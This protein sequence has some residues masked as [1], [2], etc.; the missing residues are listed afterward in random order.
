[1][2]GFLP[3]DSRVKGAFLTVFGGVCWGLSGSMGQ[4]LFTKQGMDSRWLVPIRLGL[5]GIIMF[6]YCLIRYRK[7]TFK[8]ISNKVEFRSWTIR[9]TPNSIGLFGIAFV[10]LVG[11]VLAFTSYIKGVSYI[12]PEKGILYG[13]SEPITAA[14]ITATVFRTALTP[15]DI[16]GFV[17]IFLML[18][19]I[20]RK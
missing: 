18:V 10:V 6:I 19:L 3:M 17:L 12:G 11:N 16:A 9:Y 13:F 7:D 8:P 1:M 5:A 2:K 15:Y 4:Y 14:V 20:S